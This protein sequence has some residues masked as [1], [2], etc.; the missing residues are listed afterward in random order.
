MKIPEIAIKRIYEPPASEDGIRVLADRIWPRGIK[1]ADARLDH[2]AK[3][4]APSTELRKWF[5]HDPAKWEQFRKD[6]TRELETGKETAGEIDTIRALAGGGK[7]T[8]LY[9]AH[10]S[11]HNNAVVLKDYIERKSI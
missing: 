9:A 11:A 7:I 5:A 2:W 6:Y 3:V 8:F 1:K 4:I 10:D